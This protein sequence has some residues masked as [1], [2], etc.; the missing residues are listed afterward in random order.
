[1][2]DPFNVVFELLHKLVAGSASLET[3]GKGIIKRAYLII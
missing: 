2:N 1:M 3:T